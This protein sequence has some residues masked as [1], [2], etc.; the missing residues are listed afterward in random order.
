LGKEL[1]NDILK[2]MSFYSEIPEVFFT[3]KKVRLVF[4]GVKGVAAM[5]QIGTFFRSDF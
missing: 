2:N 3:L 4:K 1:K 5:W